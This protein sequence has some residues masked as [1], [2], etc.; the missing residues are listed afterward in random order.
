MNNHETLAEKMHICHKLLQ[1]LEIS[2]RHIFYCQLVQFNPSY[3][4][5]TLLQLSLI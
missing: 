4:Y 5:N 2:K 3:N 1:N